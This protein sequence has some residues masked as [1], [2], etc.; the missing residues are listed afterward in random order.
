MFP[1]PDEVILDRYPNPHIGFGAGNHRCIGS[2]L[3]RMMFEVMIREVLARMPDYVV[4]M[5]ACEPYG[6]IS[7]VNGWVN[8]PARFTPGARISGAGV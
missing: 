2:F 4:D 1:Q 6:S 7:S 5:A 3:A 8:V